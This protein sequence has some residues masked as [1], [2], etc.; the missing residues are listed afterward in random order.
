MFIPG[1][2]HPFPLDRLVRSRFCIYIYMY[3]I[4]LQGKLTAS[5]QPISPVRFNWSVFAH[6]M[7]STPIIRK[8]VSEQVCRSCCERQVGR[9][10]S[11]N[12]FLGKE[13]TLQIDCWIYTFELVIRLSKV[14]QLAIFS[15]FT[16][17]SKCWTACRR[18]WLHL[19]DS[20]NWMR[21]LHFW[22]SNSF[23]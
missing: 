5:C 11:G 13:L 17:R 8:V 20:S 4:T 18:A 9:N 16:R 3:I 15:C 21:N 6:P 1:L 2:G 12:P 22:I 7:H 23:K 10:P 14:K 19:F